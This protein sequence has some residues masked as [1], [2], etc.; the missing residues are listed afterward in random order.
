V[1]SGVHQGSPD[2]RR[3]ERVSNSMTL[4]PGTKKLSN[5][6]TG[7]VFGGCAVSVAAFAYA[8]VKVFHGKV[9]PLATIL[10]SQIGPALH[11]KHRVYT[12]S[13]PLSLQW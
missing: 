3:L 8:Y 7:F 5:I 1:Q 9:S 10:A 4:R 11:S 12:Y 2:E 13:M 6:A